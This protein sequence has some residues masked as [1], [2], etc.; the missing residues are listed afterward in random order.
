MARGCSGK[1]TMNEIDRLKKDVEFLQLA[2]IAAPT[3]KDAEMVLQRL[4]SVERKIELLESPEL[5]S[6]VLSEI[7]NNVHN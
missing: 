5:D 2:M 4:Q 6:F 3:E 7:L 1:N